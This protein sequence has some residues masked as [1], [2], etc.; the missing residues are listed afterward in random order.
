MI[1]ACASVWELRHK[2]MMGLDCAHPFNSNR[3]HKFL[4]KVTVQLSH[5]IGLDEPFANLLVAWLYHVVSHQYQGFWLGIHDDINHVTWQ[6]VKPFSLEP[7]HPHSTSFHHSTWDKAPA[8]ACCYYYGAIGMS[9]PSL[10][11]EPRRERL[12]MGLRMV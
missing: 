12:R 9:A 5:G 2:P 8:M 6:G 11:T 7:S 1:K 4:P 10:T 3:V